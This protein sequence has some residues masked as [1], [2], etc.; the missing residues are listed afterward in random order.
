MVVARANFKQEK[1]AAAPLWRCARRAR[2]RLQR[3]FWPRLR[4]RR[5]AARARARLSASAWSAEALSWSKAL[6][7]KKA[8]ARPA[9]SL[10]L[11]LQPSRGRRR[12]PAPGRR[13]APRAARLARRAAAP[14]APAGPAAP[15]A[16][17][18]SKRGKRLFAGKS[19]ALQPEAGGRRGGALAAG[20]GAP[21]PRRG[22]GAAARPAEG[23]ERCCLLAARCF[24]ARATTWMM[25]AR[26]PGTLRKK[27][28]IWHFRHFLNKCQFSDSMS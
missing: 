11:V 22:G 3:R 18:G 2:A 7:A 14:R 9:G 4:A 24:A 20:A 12:R 19:A 15:R 23:K 17:R 5:A 6:K 8:A 21:R 27:S 10:R 25:R 1:A 16:S 26:A 13:G 28:G